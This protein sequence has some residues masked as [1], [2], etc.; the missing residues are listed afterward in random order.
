MSQKGHGLLQLLHISNTDFEGNVRS[1]GIFVMACSRVE[2]RAIS[3]FECQ[4]RMLTYLTH[5][6]DFVFGKSTKF[7]SRHVFQF[8]ELAVQHSVNGSGISP[9]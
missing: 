8:E 5:K 9:A 7:Q 1:A 3:R 6:S 2:L 4:I